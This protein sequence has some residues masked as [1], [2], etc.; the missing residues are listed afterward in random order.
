MFSNLLSLLLAVSVPTNIGATASSATVIDELSFD[1]VSYVE[2][3]ANEAIAPFSSSYYPQVEGFTHFYSY[4]QAAYVDCS[5]R[6]Y[7]H[8]DVDA[9][10]TPF[11][12]NSDLLLFHLKT[13]VTPG[14]NL[15]AFD[16]TYDNCTLNSFLVEIKLP[17]VLDVRNN[18]HTP[19]MVRLASWPSSY[20]KTSFTI[21]SSASGSISLGTSF[22]SGVGIDGLELTAEKTGG[23]TTGL[24]INFGTSTAITTED[25]YLSNQKT[26]DLPYDHHY[27]GFSWT[28]TY[29]TGG[30]TTYV[31]D[32]WCLYEMLKES[33]DGFN[34]FSFFLNLET[35]VIFNG[36]NGASSEHY[37][38][39][40]GLYYN[41]GYMPDSD[42]VQLLN[43]Y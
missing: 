32:S 13:E 7:Y 20:Q 23:I 5:P 39:R 34:D 8:Y 36:T 38:H 28:V 10:S 29:K 4:E 9:Y 6:G 11:T 26:P 21:Q 2:E 37:S 31:L 12:T 17:V 19:N 43:Q 22:T 40:S 27:N 3:D 14:S 41:L 18:Y 30:L 15:H 1:D 35:D 24:N 33:A 42:Y 25:P 16:S